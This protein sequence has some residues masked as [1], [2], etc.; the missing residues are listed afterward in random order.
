MRNV[1]DFW[2]DLD[3]EQKKGAT[4]VEKKY[5][6]NR[7][8]ESNDPVIILK[9]QIDEPFL[10]ISFPVYVDMLG[11]FLET[12]ISSLDFAYG[13]K[14]IYEEVRMALKR[15]E[16]GIKQSEEHK[17]AAIRNCSTRIERI[18]QEELPGNVMILDVTEERR[19]EG[20]IDTA[21]YDG[22]LS[23]N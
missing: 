18:I 6:A 10:V 7:W 19:N 13:K 9:H 4:K 20:E 5:G 11:K 3:P 8:W 1:F 15:K 16:L 12:P 23:P 17:E 14:E 22:W 21:G 2:D